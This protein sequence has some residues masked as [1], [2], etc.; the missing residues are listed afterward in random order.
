M[1][2]AFVL[3][4]GGAKGA[5]HIGFYK[6]VHELNINPDIVTGT[7]IG[8]LVGCMIAQKDFEEAVNLWEN[9]DISQIMNEGISFSTNLETMISQSNRIIPFFKKY[10][11]YKGADITPFKQ[12]IQTLSSQEKLMN[13]SIDFGCVSVE[14]PSLEP[15]EITKKEMQENELGD[16]LLASASC[17]PAFPIHEFNGK[18]YIDG[19]YYDNLPAQL[20]RKMGAEELILVDL[21]YQK[22]THAEY[23]NRPAITYIS[24]TQD[25]GNFLDFSPE[26]IKRRI[27][28]GYLD[29]MKAF[30]HYDG[31]LYTYEKSN[32]HKKHFLRF[33]Q[34]ILDNEAAINAF[35]IRKK[36]KVFNSQPISDRLREFT[37]LPYLEIADY[38]LAAMEICASVLEIDTLKIYDLNTLRNLILTEYQNLS[39][40]NIGLSDSVKEMANF[41]SNL[42]RRQILLIITEKLNSNSFIM[43]Q[44]MLSLAIDEYIAALYLNKQIK[45]MPK[46]R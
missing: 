23:L 7:S 10:I 1:K 38:E 25:L 8:A 4:G 18:G 37:A 16:Y 12:M 30:K 40:S 42:D 43:E 2:K 39:D 41:V 6:A 35:A 32:R 36:I 21:H 11:Q 45:S 22:P 19:G 13:S 44:A 46:A 29:T 26:V 28:L 27:Q 17:F 31:Y 33:Y 24:P 15:V 5:Y 34:M 3:A 20:A 9:L 14:Y